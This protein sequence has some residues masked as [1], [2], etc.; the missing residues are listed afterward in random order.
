MNIL[1]SS[2][3][4]IHSKVDLTTRIDVQNSEKSEIV[5]IADISALIASLSLFA[6]N[7]LLADFLATE[8]WIFAKL[9]LQMLNSTVCNT[10]FHWKTK[11]YGI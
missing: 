3:T 4:S 2:E 7:L 6:I 1:Y 11:K 10:E 8:I 9:N 5:K